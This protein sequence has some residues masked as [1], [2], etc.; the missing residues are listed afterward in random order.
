[1]GQPRRGDAWRHY[2]VWRGSGFYGAS[3]VADTGGAAVSLPCH[4]ARTGEARGDAGEGGAAVT[5]A[6]GG[7]VIFRVLVVRRKLECRGGAAGGRRES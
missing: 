1:M 3:S 4:G 7:A 2:T 5:Q 6:K